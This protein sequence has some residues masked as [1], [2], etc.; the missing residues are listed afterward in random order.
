MRGLRALVVLKHDGISKTDILKKAHGRPQ[1]EENSQTRDSSPEQG[2]TH[3]GQA[4]ED[5]ATKGL[6]GQ[7]GQALGQERCWRDSDL[8]ERERQERVRAQNRGPQ[9]RHHASCNSCFP[10]AR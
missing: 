2:R 8:E 6:G 4:S 1:W 7:D 3:E 5:S 10:S 9:A